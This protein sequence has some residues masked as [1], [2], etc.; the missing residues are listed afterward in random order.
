[1]MKNKKIIWSLA[2]TGIL[3]IIILSI[4][5]Y[6]NS[7]LKPVDSENVEKIVIEVPMGSSTSSISVLLKENDLI[8]NEK[9]FQAYVKYKGLDA[10][11]K[12]GTYT[13]SKSMSVENILLKLVDGNIKIETVRFTIPEG[14]NVEQIADKLSNEGLVDKETFL[15]LANS[16]DY[17]YD[18]I[19][20]IPEDSNIKY[21]LEGYLFPETYEI[22][23]DSTE[24]D[25]IEVMLSQFEKEWQNTWNDAIKSNNMTL[26][27]IVT[28]ASIVEREAVADSERSTIAGVFYNRI[29]DLWLLESCATVQ[30]ALGEQKDVLYLD[31]LEIDDAYNTYINA[32]LPP[33]PIASSGRKSLE[34]T[35]Y[36]E[37]H[38]YYFFVTKKDGTGEHY[39]SKTLAEHNNYDSQSR[40]NN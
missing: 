16:L 22:M 20:E 5:I 37:T 3:L 6:V 10:S 12:A 7:S 8:K 11:L 21:K 36:P 19:K 35:V 1:M 31:D 18:F 4:F 27:Q 34:A 9:T 2:I 25:I 29:E 13:L 32:G 24:K 28:L 38:P 39:F 15:E 23:T 14:Y 17:D 30:Y 40:G 26:H 33:G